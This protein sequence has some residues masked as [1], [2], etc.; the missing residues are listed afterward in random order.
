MDNSPV[1]QSNQVGDLTAAVQS[2]A[3]QMQALM[4]QVSTLTSEVSTLRQENSLLKAAQ[5]AG[6]QQP[7]S[8][9]DQRNALAMEAV[10]A[11]LTHLPQAI[12]QQTPKVPRS[13]ID[14]RG[15]G[16]PPK[17]DGTEASFRRWAMRV[18]D[19]V[20]AS[21]TDAREILQH[22]VDPETESLE[23]SDISLHLG[24]DQE[25]IEEFDKQLFNALTSL[26]DNES[27]DVIRAC[28]GG[29]GLLAWKALCRRFDPYTAG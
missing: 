23:A 4:G 19:W 12:A 21:F 18:E 17:F 25:E 5:D 9:T 20:S 15:L 27:H 26:T 24:I 2:M 1:R 16:R 3:A 14:N 11:A 13:L 8:S 10:A 7:G 28:G 6:P 22:A 29:H